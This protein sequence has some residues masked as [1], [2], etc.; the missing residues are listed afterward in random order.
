MYLNIVYEQIKKILNL[1]F[2]F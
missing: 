1:N 2:V